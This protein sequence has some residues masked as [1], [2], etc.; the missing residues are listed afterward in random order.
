MIDLAQSG[1][2]LPSSTRHREEDGDLPR[3]R[4]GR[5]KGEDN[6][7][8]LKQVLKTRENPMPSLF[9]QFLAFST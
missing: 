5:E 4:K 3:S 8:F 9:A 1:F 2:S 6:Q 7:C